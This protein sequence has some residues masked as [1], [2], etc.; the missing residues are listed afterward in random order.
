MRPLRT[1][2]EMTGG[3]SELNQAIYRSSQDSVRATFGKDRGKAIA[4]YAPLLDFVS[5]VQPPQRLALPTRLLDVGCGSGWSTL[6]FAEAGYDATGV[7]LNPAAFEPPPHESLHLGQGSAIDIPFPENSFD[8]VVCYQCIEHVP[9]PGRALKEMM[10]VCRS[11]GIVAIVGPNLVSPLPG[12]AY[13][14]KPS[15][16]RSL[17]FWRR[18]G[19]PRHPY[20]NTVPEILGVA[21]L[22]LAQLCIKAAAGPH[23]T[24]REPDTAPP[25]HADNDACYLCNP[26][27]LIKY[28]KSLGCSIERGGKPGRPAFAYALAGGTW[29]AARKPLAG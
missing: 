22:R 18:P 16:W 19:M 9:D 25:F 24:M 17:R 7:D 27:D 10:R 29:V 3:M 5:S 11:G 8:V 21:L 2:L 20:G 28:F 15:S 6:A 23:F 1:A 14:V 4:Y 26:I 12:L 13:A